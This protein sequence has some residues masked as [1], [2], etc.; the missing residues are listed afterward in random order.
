MLST[1]RV[2]RLSP[3]EVIDLIC[4]VQPVVFVVWQRREAVTDI[5]LRALVPSSLSSEWFRLG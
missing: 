5:S 1:I 2:A 3:W 4:T